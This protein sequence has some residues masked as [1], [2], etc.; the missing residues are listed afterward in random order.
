MPEEDTLRY[1]E[2]LRENI[3]LWETEGRV[4]IAAVG[5][6]PGFLSLLDIIYN[7]RFQQFLPDMDLVG[8]A[9]PGLNRA[10][11]EYA[12]S[13]GIPIYDTL[14]ALLEDF[15]D[16]NLVV[17]H[18]GLRKTTARLRKLLPDNVSLIDNTG[19]VFLCGLHDLAQANAYC[20][21]TLD[22]HRTLLQAIIDEVRE[23]ILLLDSHGRVVDC[24]RNVLEKAGKHKED[25]IGKQ[26]FEADIPE[27]GMFCSIEGDEHCAYV[28]ALK[29]GEKTEAMFTRVDEEGNL[30]YYRIYAYPIM[31]ETGRINHVVVMRRDITERTRRERMQQQ[32]EKLAVVGEMSTYLAHEIRNPL[33]A[34][35]GFTNSLLKS[36]TATPKEREKLEIIAKETA[37]LEHLLSSILKFSRPSAAEVD[38]VNLNDVADETATLMRMGYEHQGYVIE[39]RPTQTIP[40]IKAEPELVKQCI[41]NLIKNSVEAMPRGGSLQVRTGREGDMVILEVIDKGHGMSELQMDQAFSPFY[42]TKEQ[43]CGL[44]LAMIR[45]IVDE[46]GGSV[47]LK[48]KEG[49]GTT[50]TL[51]FLPVLAEG[52]G[53]GAEW[54]QGGSS[55]EGGA[56]P[57]IVSREHDGRGNAKAEE[58]GSSTNQN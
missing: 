27:G 54:V 17:E 47:R 29:T 7:E 44:G 32:A 40:L 35:A 23:D 11:L 24:N 33:F 15:P 53:E 5:T 3:C 39:F 50:V 46:F 31:S 58:I 9:E 10:K 45:K 12:K 30:K 22:R 41:V 19:T 55:K 48:S 52:L 42:T 25:F 38:K 56:A 57:Q 34:I 1:P 2:E 20:Q 21:V 26:F 18:T 28:Q 36:D 49:E 4:R 14:E 43:G 8:V 6:G 37:R 13:L 16:V 51:S